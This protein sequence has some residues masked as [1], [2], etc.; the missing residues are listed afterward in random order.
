MNNTKHRPMNTQQR[1]YT[2]TVTLRQG[3]K[4]AKHIRHGVKS[5]A[6]GIQDVLAEAGAEPS[7]VVRVEATNENTIKQ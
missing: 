6:N 4:Q 1:T 2:L 7:D 5:W 3:G